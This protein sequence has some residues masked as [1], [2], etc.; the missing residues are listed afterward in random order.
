MRSCKH[1]HI[2]YASNVL[3]LSISAFMSFDFII[4]LLLFTDL[5]NVE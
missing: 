3:W 1:F 2:I 5:W 4:C